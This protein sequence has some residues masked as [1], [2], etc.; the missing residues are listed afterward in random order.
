MFWFFYS[1]FWI[2]VGLWISCTKTQTLPNLR[3][4]TTSGPHSPPLTRRVFLAP[5][6][7]H[8]ARFWLVESVA[9]PTLSLAAHRKGKKDTARTLRR[10]VYDIVSRAKSIP[11]S[12]DLWIAMR[13][14]STLIPIDGNLL[15][16][17]RDNSPII[18]AAWG[19]FLKNVVPRFTS[20]LTKW[21]EFKKSKFTNFHLTCF[22]HYFHHI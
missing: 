12:H 8:R 16:H 6:V 2:L 13:Q 22:H 10:R 18:T 9:R 20:H 4:L 21:S 3:L 7:I 14:S 1:W 5:V 15:S 11:Q 17:S 19:G